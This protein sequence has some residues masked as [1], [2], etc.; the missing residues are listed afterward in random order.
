[1]FRGGGFLKET[2]GTV[3]FASTVDFARTVDFGDT[4]EKK[5]AFGLLG[6][7][8]CEGLQTFFEKQLLDSFFTLRT[9]KL[10]VGDD[11]K[12]SGR[13]ISLTPSITCQSI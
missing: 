1:V 5:T 3:D 9:R 4:V 10:M 2:T 12:V 13:L 6:T 7:V 11:K 8:I